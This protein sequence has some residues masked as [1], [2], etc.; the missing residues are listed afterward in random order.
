MKFLDNVSE[1][2]LG[3]YFQMRPNQIRQ[4]L[5][6]FHS[7]NPQQ[8]LSSCKQKGVKIITLFDNEF[9]LLL[10]QIFDPPW[11]LYAKG[12]LEISC[13]KK[14]IGVVGSRTPTTNAVESLRKILPDLID[15]EYMIT[16]G[17]AYGVDTLAH[18]ITCEFNGDTVAVIGSGF[19]YIYPRKHISFSETLAK[20][21]L[22]L[23][24]YPP[25]TRP[26]KWHFPARNRIISGLTRGV[27]VVEAKKKSGS[28]ITAD[29]ALEQGREVFAIPGSI[30]EP[31]AEGTNFLI[32]QG[33]KLVQNSTD[34][35]SELTE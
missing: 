32:Q 16:S 29:Q 9:P 18:K 13:R 17:L 19:D 21:H 12:K 31:N 30:H 11:V 10:R 15:N 3:T 14:S 2:D 25:Y 1:S 8:L 34:I 5:Q 33:A 28:L 27:L 20:H 22:L 26:Q 24:E 6:S 35:L 4:F 7:N 23:S